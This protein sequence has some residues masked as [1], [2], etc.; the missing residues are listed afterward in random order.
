MARIN[1]ERFGDVS[2]KLVGAVFQQLEA[3]AEDQALGDSEGA[4][5]G[6]ESR[7]P[8]GCQPSQHYM[9]M[10]SEASRD[11]YVEVFYLPLQTRISW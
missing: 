10:S 2:R 6:E 5:G 4:S 8:T 7:W 1:G 9:T 11:G 3:A